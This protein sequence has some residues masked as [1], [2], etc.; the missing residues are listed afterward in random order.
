[1]VTREW[2]SFPP[3]R[4]VPRY[5]S[6]QT[7][8]GESSRCLVQH[9]S[10]G[11]GHHSSRFGIKSR[12]IFV[13]ELT[14]DLLSQSSTLLTSCSTA[15]APHTSKT[16]DVA[17]LLSRIAHTRNRIFLILAAVLAFGFLLVRPAVDIEEEAPAFI[18]PYRPQ[19]VEHADGG[20]AFSPFKALG[21][22]HFVAGERQRLLIVGGASQ[23]GEC[24]APASR[25]L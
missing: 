6:T 2:R 9:R 15:S 16:V 5:Q 21:L 12:S 11:H 8:V 13:D 1:M 23:I 3:L 14:F 22:D 7:S 19:K 25:Y 24:S 4:R 18:S 17:M 20:S 10:S